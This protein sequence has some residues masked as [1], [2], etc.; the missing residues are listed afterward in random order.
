MSFAQFIVFPEIRTIFGR[1]QLQCL[2][3]FIVVFHAICQNMENSFEIEN[4]AIQC[5]NKL[6]K[7]K[8]RK[9]EDWRRPPWSRKRSS[10]TGNESN[11]EEEIVHYHHQIL[12]TASLRWLLSF[13]C[14]PFWDQTYKILARWV[15]R[16]RFTWKRDS[17]LQNQ[18]S[19][20][21]KCRAVWTQHYPLFLEQKCKAKNWMN[22]LVVWPRL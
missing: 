9:E 7:I 4:E 6:A 21:G 19:W 8:H 12:K 17:K 1:C 13:A 5:I 20:K 11:L 15:T 18:A 10:G 22:N 14:P 3:S 2:S 16:T